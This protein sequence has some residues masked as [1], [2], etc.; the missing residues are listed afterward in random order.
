MSPISSGI[1]ITLRQESSEYQWNYLQMQL[2]HEVNRV[3]L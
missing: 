1:S 2:F 3:F